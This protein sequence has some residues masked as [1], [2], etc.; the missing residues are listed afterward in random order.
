MQK[1][2]TAFIL[3]FIF[4]IFTTTI[5]AQGVTT[6][7]LNGIVTDKENDPLPFANIIAIHV[8]SGVEYGVASQNNG[9]FTLQNIRIGGPYKIT[10][11]FVGY[12]AQTKEDVFLAL[13]QNV[14]VEFKLSDESVGLSEIV[15]SSHQDNDLNADRT[16]AATNISKKEIDALPTISRST[17]DYTRLTPQ[18]SGGSF[19][20]RNSYYNNFSL[21]GSIF[22][23]SF[24]LDVPTPGG[25]TNAQ[26]V[27]L[28]AIDQIQVTLAP[29]DVRQ[30]GFTGAGI[31]SV[32]KSGT[33]T[34]KGSVYSFIRN[35]SMIGKKVGNLELENPNLSYGLYGF[36]VGGPILENK[37]FFFVNAEM[38][39]REEPATTLL[40]SKPGSSGAN[41]SNVSASD[42]D[43]IQKTLKDVY[44]YETGAYENY[45]HKTENEK[46]LAK[47]DWNINQDH[48]FSFRYN[49]LRSWRD[50][51]PHPAIS[52]G[53]RG[54]N[55]NSLPFENTSYIINNDINSFV[56]QLTS[57][58]GN[59]YSNHLTVAYTAFRDYR[60]SKSANFPSI[61]INK[62]GLNYA[63]F[64]LERFSTNNILDQN[65]FQ[66]TDDFSIYMNDHI[67]TVGA[68]ME[69][70]G[71]MNSFN[72]FYYP[73]YT[74]ASMDDFRLHTNPN[75]PA[76]FND[77]NAD[78]A[79]SNTKPYKVAEFS[80]GQVSLYAQDEWQVNDK[81]KLTGGI[82]MDMPTY[83][84]KPEANPVI[85]AKTFKDEFGNDVKIDVS[86]LP[87]AT[88][89]LSP[90][91]GFNYDVK[92]DRSTQLRGGTGVF[93]GRLRFVWI[94]NQFSNRTIDP[95][96]TF[97]I[98]ATSENFKWPQVWRTDFAIDQELPWGMIG[99]LEG[100]Y[101]KDI[102]AVVHKNYNMD[103]PTGTLKGADNRA[104]YQGSESKINDFT[105]VGSWMDAGAIVLDN[106]DEGYQYSMT[107]KLRKNFSPFAFAMVAYTYAQSKDITSSPGE[108]AADAFQLNP[109]VGNNNTPKLSYSDWGMDHRF[110]GAGSWK[111]VY[112]GSYATTISLFFETGSGSRFS[113]TYAGDVN[114]DGI[115]QNN[116]LIYVP[117]NSSEINL[118]PTDA[119][120]TRSPEEIWN[121]LNSYIEQDDYLSTRRGDYAERNGSIG[122]WFSQ[123]DLRILQDF[124]IN[125][126]E[127]TH[128]F[129]LS[130]D[131]LNVGNMINSDW[132]VR[133]FPQNKSPLSL[134]GYNAQG[135][136]E[137]AFPTSNGKVMTTT[138][139]DNTS[140][141][142]RW[143]MQIGLRYLFN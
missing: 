76:N 9:R 54:P 83:F 127:N 140:I 114:K 80:V 90:R 44:G 47:I 56:S 118:V 120:D 96:Y 34:F 79:N 98:N 42:L 70:F 85:E 73:G 61:D 142:S 67:I 58:F 28:D 25:Q 87:S 37:L 100:I 94:G 23:N 52:A 66:I 60:E 102:N 8:P 86:H 49:Y 138:F 115:G 88:P 46:L 134:A 38:E 43:E 53:G 99:T 124:A 10:A 84:D 82:R 35:E 7:S 33:N 141:A 123:I 136:P 77:F 40:A 4:S 132:G 126:G 135:E 108:I 21:D 78:V 72:L 89:L 93:T 133:S 143:Q 6:A 3:I 116:D 119:S 59:N 31:N 129:Q 22:N 117:A 45:N 13:G 103:V 112:G 16:G 105:D 65:V 68:S 17:S 71:F 64:G 32:T 29:Y 74:F 36:R 5:F 19:G 24:G 14:R 104:V 26:P 27:S 131:V 51:L 92:G 106:T 63:S 125:I 107:A 128:A 95:F 50:V 113:Y 20:G 111:F 81:L 11:S 41:V 97:Q 15:V 121:Q 2:F 12:Q 91:I 101:N 137:F 109:V 62:N 69:T 18:A 139:I 1:L 30:G 48:D 57:R 130:L 39:R 75:D 55:L 110:I 122:E